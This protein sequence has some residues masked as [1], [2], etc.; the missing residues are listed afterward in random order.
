MRLIRRCWLLLQVRICFKRTDR[1]C[2]SDIG[3]T[4]SGESVYIRFSDVTG[5]S[6]GFFALLLY[7]FALCISESGVQNQNT[8][9]VQLLCIF[10]MM[11]AVP[12]FVTKYNSDDW[13]LSS[14][15]ESAGVILILKERAEWLIIPF[16]ALA[17]MVHQGYV[18]MFFNILL[19]LLFVKCCDCQ[20]KKQQ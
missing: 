9:R 2:L 19:V 16:V 6:Q 8:S 4:A 5:L 15:A 7:F 17:T 12:F 10:Y 3:C 11:F 13:I 20:G 18:F 1:K 14:D